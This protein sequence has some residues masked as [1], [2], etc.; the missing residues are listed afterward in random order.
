MTYREVIKELESLKNEKGLKHYEKIFGKKDNYLGLGLTVLRKLAKKIKINANL[1]QE[2]MESDYVE[3]KMLSI[4]IDDPN[5]YDKKRIDKL[6]KKLPQHYSS[7]PL[8]YYIMV[9]TEYIIAKSPEVEQIINN[10]AKSKNSTDRFIAYSTLANLG[11]MGKVEDKYFLPFLSTIEK[12][13]QNEDNNVKDVMN[14]SMLYW[15]QRSKDLHEK[16]MKAS[17][18]IGTITVDYGDTSCQTPN[19]PLIL[20]SDRILNKLS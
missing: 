7:S 17:N 4:M 18:N 15:G 16:V 9:L 13:I 3:A 2:L 6:V 5:E 1:A 20:S 19:V 10:Y 14:N 11:K 12:T 8:S